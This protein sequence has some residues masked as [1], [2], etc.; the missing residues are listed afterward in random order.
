MSDPSSPPVGKSK[1]GL[2]KKP[3][4]P[5]RNIIGLVVLV[6]VVVVGGLEYSAKSGYNTAVTALDARTKDESRELMTASESEG[7]LGRAPDGPARDVQVDGRTFAKKTFTW[8]GALKSYTVAAFY[9]KH[10]DARLHH[11]ET[12][13]ATPT[14][15]AAD[16]TAGPP[17]APA[18]APVAAAPAPAAAA[19]SPAPASSPAPAA[20]VE[21]K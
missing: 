17:S 4:S 9:T 3:V 20:P 18:A 11:F 16:E 1:T 19:P 12:P 21:T 5:A 13:G 15:E 2:T 14:P 8:R 7:L 10:A 6:V